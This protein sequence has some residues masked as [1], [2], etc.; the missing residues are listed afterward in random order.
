MRELDL[1]YVYGMLGGDIQNVPWEGGSACRVWLEK[2]PPV[3]IIRELAK[4][5]FNV[6]LKYTNS[7]IH[8]PVEA[9]VEKPDGPAEAVVV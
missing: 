8:G 7:K 6:T 4:H 5:G 2:R 3:R 1:N 9:R